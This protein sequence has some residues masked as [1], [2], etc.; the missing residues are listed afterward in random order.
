[1]VAALDRLAA[2]AEA[3]DVRRLAG[4]PGWLLLRVGDHRV[5][6]RPLSET[7]AARHGRGYLVA[8]VVHRR[9]PDTAVATL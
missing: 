9:D 7:E 6:Y 5:L 3:L 1:M 4:N 8:R 2:G